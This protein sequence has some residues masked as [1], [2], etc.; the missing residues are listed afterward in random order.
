MVG[1]EV[2]KSQTHRSTPPRASAHGGVVRSRPKSFR[3][4]VRCLDNDVV[5]REWQTAF[6]CEGDAGCSASARVLTGAGQ[7]NREK[8]RVLHQMA[9]R[10]LLVVCRWYPSIENADMINETFGAEFSALTDE[11]QV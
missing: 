8:V 10:E 11:E 6:V 9:A 1:W 5:T 7:A 4:S 3:S 2:S